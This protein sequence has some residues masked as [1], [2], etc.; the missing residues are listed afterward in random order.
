MSL[1]ALSAITLVALT[2]VLY[3]MI[4]FKKTMADYKD[5]ID[6]LQKIVDTQQSETKV[7]LTA[8][9]TE[10]RVI[11]FYDDV[12]PL[13]KDK[14]VAELFERLAKDEE[15]HITLLENCLAGK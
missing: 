8:Y 13:I 6:R 1:F 12:S 15:K 7:L 10:S 5:Q 11:S 4:D 3:S 14:E 2:Y 9:M